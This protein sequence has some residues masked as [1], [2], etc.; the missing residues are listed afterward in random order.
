MLT[1]P[2]GCDERRS[3]STQEHMAELVLRSATSIVGVSPGLGEDEVVVTQ[4]SQGVAVY[5]IR[6]RACV[7]G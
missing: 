3:A 2:P 4:Q 1:S 7:Q 5:N 6:S